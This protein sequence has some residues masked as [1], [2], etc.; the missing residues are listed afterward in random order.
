VYNFGRHGATPL[1]TAKGR[2]RRRC[3]PVAATTRSLAPRRTH[4]EDHP[5]PKRPLPVIFLDDEEKHELYVDERFTGIHPLVRMCDGLAMLITG[6]GKRKRVYCK[7]TDVLAWY[8]KE[9]A[10]V[11]T[12]KTY[13]E[14]IAMIESVLQRYHNGEIARVD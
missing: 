13:Q 3:S 1:V 4:A 11:P 12:N 5:M 14:R 9:S 6:K 8:R 2:R 10:D 7:V